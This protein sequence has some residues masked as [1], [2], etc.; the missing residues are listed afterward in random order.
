MKNHG[1][2]KKIGALAASVLC[3]MSGS[4]IMISQGSAQATGSP[5]ILT[6][7]TN[8]GQTFTNNFNPANGVSTGTQMALNSL[9]YE[10]LMQFN[11]LKPGVS[12]PWLATKE[13]FGPTG[14]TV[15]FTISPKASW[16]NGVPLTAKHVANEFNAISNNGS[17]NIFGIPALAQPATATGNT[18]TLTFATPQYSNEQALGSVLIFP[19]TGD[20]GIPAASLITS[21]T[22]N[23]PA[24]RVIGSG[25]YVPTNYTSQLISYSYNKNWKITKKPYVTGI[26]IPYYASN[27]AA[28][29]AL[30]SHQLDWAGNDIPQ[31]TKTFVALD[32]VHNHYYFPGGSTVTLW[33]NV[34]RSAPDG[35]TSC[36]ADASFRKIISMAV[37]RKQLAQIGETGYAA[38]ATSSSGMTPIQSSF[39]GSYVNDLPQTGWS[40][41]QVGSAMRAKGYALDSHGYFAVSSARAKSATGL[42]AGT[43]CAFKIQDP[44]GYSDYFEDQQLISQQL[45]KDHINITAIGVTT[46]QWL[47][48]IGTHNF[49]AIIHW[50]AGGTNPYSQFQNW[51]QDSA[52]SG[53][54]ANYGQY[55]NAPAQALLL[56][57]AADRP[58]TAQFQTDANKLSAIMSNEVPAAPLLY[59]PDW[60]VYSTTRFKGWVTPT[61]QYGYPG[62]GGNNLPYVLMKLKKS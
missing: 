43:E 12:Y 55:Q 13:V 57:L 10:P 7:E 35:N 15:T 31:I 9:S 1:A 62:P 34:S 49:D 11:P 22:V 4:L 29:E 8:V 42:P 56:A 45:Q 44:T 5:T 37:N 17:L 28:T 40:S 6:E 25:P 41:A 20:A 21:G 24:N 3:L 39:Q 2:V 18:V 54:W 23:L 14:Q 53:G 58:G 60:S 38:T 33:F 27:Q 30:V 51:L 52:T 16:S 50:G 32:T 26:N 36:L 46:G 61:N 19:V 47:S 48:N 59:G